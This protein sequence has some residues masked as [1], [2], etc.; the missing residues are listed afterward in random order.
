M[1][2]NLNKKITIILLAVLSIMTTGCTQKNESIANSYQNSI[3]EYL[4]SNGIDGYSKVYRYDELGKDKIYVYIST[5]KNIDKLN[6]EVIS[7]LIQ[8]I[9][10]NVLSSN[11]LLCEIDIVG[12]ERSDLPTNEHIEISNH[13][14]Y[15]D[16]SWSKELS[17]MYGNLNMI[18][19]LSDS[20]IKEIEHLT[21]SI[22][23]TAQNPAP[24]KPTDFLLNYSGLKKLHLVGLG[25][26]S[27]KVTVSQSFIND[28]KENLPHDCTIECFP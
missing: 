7:E 15:D 21:I 13:L 14:Y 17:Y 8:F 2:N 26:S 27:N 16:S 23:E 12:N 18:I 19:Q 3:S 5:E 20:E 25:D 28:L 11:N 6:A 22:S 1:I 9:N 10:I 24:I 4:Y